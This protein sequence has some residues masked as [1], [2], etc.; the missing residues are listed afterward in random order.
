[1]EKGWDPTIV[2]VAFSVMT[3]MSLPGSIVGGAVKARFGNKLVLKIGGL[4]FALTC[5]AASFVTGPW[6][7][8]VLR[9]RMSANCS[10]TK[11]VWQ[12][13]SL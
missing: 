13:V 10:R 9:W 4:G 2:V 11:E 1:M 8:V 12:Q 7:Y 5:V 3:F 6:G